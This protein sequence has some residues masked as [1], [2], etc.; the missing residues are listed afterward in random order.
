MNG[1]NISRQDDIDTIEM[2]NYYMTN[3]VSIKQVSEKFKLS[4]SGIFKRFKKLNLKSKSRNDTRKIKVSNF[5]VQHMYLDRKLSIEEISKITGVSNGSIGNIIKKLGISRTP[6]DSKS[7]KY[8]TFVWTSDKDNLAKNL[9]IKYKNYSIVAN[10]LGCTQIALENRNQKIIK[11]SLIEN[12][13]LLGIP[14]RGRDGIIYSSK[15]EASIANML[16]SLN[17]NYATQVKVCKDK[18]WTC[19]FLVNDLWIEAD[20][21]SNNRNN[22]GEINYLEGNPKI[23]YYKSNSYKFFIITPYKWKT[24]LLSILRKHSVLC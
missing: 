8:N 9:L 22:I 7:A 14:T 12:K 21:L 19:D 17:I 23:E 3:N 5:T 18:Q 13:N 16:Y 20:G 2:Y 6:A 24:V 15:F 4:P 11:V 1:S 10:I